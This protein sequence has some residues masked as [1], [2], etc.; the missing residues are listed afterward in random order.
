[1]I[2]FARTGGAYVDPK[3]GDDA[4]TAREAADRARG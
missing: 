4:Q 1:M 2:G 3:P